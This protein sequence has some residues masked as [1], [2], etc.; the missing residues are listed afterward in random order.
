MFINVVFI[1]IVFINTKKGRI[2]R[3]TLPKLKKV[4]S[5][6]IKKKTKKT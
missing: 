2:D 6:G 3:K 1:N 4:I 5:K